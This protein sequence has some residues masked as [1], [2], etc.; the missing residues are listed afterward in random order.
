MIEQL[1]WNFLVVMEMKQ[2]VIWRYWRTVVRGSVLDSSVKVYKR[3]LTVYSRIVSGT[4]VTCKP[5][6][7]CHRHSAV[8]W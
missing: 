5:L 3:G 4:S 2:L 6:R 8:H 7:V 1:L